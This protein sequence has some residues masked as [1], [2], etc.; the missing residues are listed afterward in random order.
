MQ[1]GGCEGCAD[2]IIVVMN[3]SAVIDLAIKCYT[4]KALGG[5]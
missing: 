4:K 5:S 3:T 2:A 1:T